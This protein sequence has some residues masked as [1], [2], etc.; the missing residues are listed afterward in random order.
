MQSCGPPGIEFETSGLYHSLL[1]LISALNE[2]CYLLIGS[3]QGEEH[4]AHITRYE[5]HRGQSHEPAHS[6]PPFRE[7]IVVQFKRNHLH[8]AEEEHALQRSSV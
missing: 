1:Y 6:L 5:N 3:L 2:N 8:R 4:V 7:H